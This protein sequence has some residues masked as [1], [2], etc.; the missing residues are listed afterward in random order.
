MTSTLF[1][2]PGDGQVH[3][4]RVRAF[5]APVAANAGAV[6]DDPAALDIADAVYDAFADLDAAQGLTRAQLLD[7]CKHACPDLTEL[8]NRLDLFARMGMLQLVKAHQQRYQFNPTSAAALMVF[9]RLAEDG[10]VQEIITVLDRTRGALSDGSATHGQVRDA[11]VKLRRAFAV[12]AAHLERLAANRPLV[13]VMQE[14][15]HHRASDRLLKDAEELIRLVIARFPDL[16][17]ASNRLILD[18]TRYNE[19]VQVV[20]T[21]LLDEASTH[22]DF[23]MLDAEQYRTA[24]VTADRHALAR[25]FNAVMFD[26]PSPPLDADAVITAIDQV[27]PRTVRRRPPR[28]EAAPA[29]PDPVE[30]A[31]ERAEK[32]R[33]RRESVLER[34]LDGEQ[35]A[36][37]T[38]TVRMAG[39]PGAGKLV[40]DLLAADADPNLP[41]GVTLS[42]AVLV[43]AEGT[44]THVTPVMIHRAGDTETELTALIAAADGDAVKIAGA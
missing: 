2:G 36:D 5:V 9:E 23:S 14:R 10:G 35:S 16:A 30:A 21:R 19:A 34:G 11:L 1:D 3:L 4:S 13:E 7:R 20:I 8:N 17:A 12:N 32:V 27:R 38:T 18:A 31:R 33:R 41:Y 39:W 37:V 29:G 40:A 15:R 25:P 43:H 26:P 44:V 22:R 42:T 28:P 24:A 6:D